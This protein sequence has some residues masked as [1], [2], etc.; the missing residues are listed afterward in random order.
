M[1]PAQR[2]H[3]NGAYVESKNSLIPAVHFKRIFQVTVNIL[4]A[5]VNL[6]GKPSSLVCKIKE[7]RQMHVDTSVFTDIFHDC[8]AKAT[9]Q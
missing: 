2:V 6:P 4:M 3:Y 8:M 9:E 7:A 1:E 5:S